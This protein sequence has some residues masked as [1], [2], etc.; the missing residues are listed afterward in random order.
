MLLD[1]SREYEWPKIDWDDLQKRI[2]TLRVRLVTALAQSSTEL[3]KLPSAE[4]LPDFFGHA[5]TILSEESFTAMADGK[6]ELFGVV[7]P[8]FFKLALEGSERLRKKF[9]TDTRNLQLSIEPLA[10]LAAL[11]GYAAV[12]SE[13]DNKKFWALV[14]HCWDQYF[15]L[16][17][18]DDQK[19][20][21]IQLLCLA[22]EPTL[23]MTP[24]SVMRTRW[25]RMCDG[26]FAARGL[27][28][29]RALWHGTRDSEIRH[30]SSLV[31]IF[32]RSI[33]LLNDPCVVFLALY[34]FKRP[35]AVGL[36]KPRQI[37]SLERDLQSA[38]DNDLPT[39][40]E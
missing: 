24:R 7:F 27:V 31:R 19:R 36:K 25:Q 33:H 14:E 15:A 32:S 34:V 12:F 16:F 26:I 37:I 23:R 30:P 1:R 35:E 11:S 10:D 17:A 2:A 21:V 13:M 9:L 18:D 20:H 40:D 8:A 39:G 29:E 6:D 4:V 38:T 28:S 3:A 22:I 5:Y